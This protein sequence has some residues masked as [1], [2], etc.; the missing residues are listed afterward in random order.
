MLRWRLLIG[1]PLVALLIFLLWLDATL[2]IPGLILLPFFLICEFFLCR[3]TIA[4]LNAGGLFPRRSTIYAGVFGTLLLCW[5]SCWNAHPMMSAVHVR[6]QGESGAAAVAESRSID[7]AEV[8]EL[9]DAGALAALES[10]EQTVAAVRAYLEERN[11]STQG[12]QGG[13]A[14]G[15]E[16]STVVGGSYAEVGA[17]K[18]AAYSCVHILLAIAAGVLIAFV[19]EMLRFKLPGGHMINLSGAIFAIVYLGL[20]GSFLVMLRLTYGVSA[21][22]SMI[23]TA[24]LCDIGAY[25]VGRMI[26][27]HKM[28]PSLSPGKTIEGI[29]GG[30]IF[31]TIGA[32]ASVRFLFP[33]EFGTASSTTALGAIIYGLVVGAVGALGDLAESLIKRDVSRKD[34]GTHVPGF[35]GFLDMFDSLLLAAPVAFALWAFG[36]VKP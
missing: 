32:W 33:L 5:A 18:T 15:R 14:A 3:E 31:S 23:V 10:A 20:L 9:D 29:C 2:P 21:L 4:L 25:T 27:R 13:I 36:V 7:R 16:A 22:V 6:A 26:G 35:G 28:A 19:G 1:I 30:L 8:K 34:S 12:K 24:K 11:S 17:W